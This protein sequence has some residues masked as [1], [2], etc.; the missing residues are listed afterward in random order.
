MTVT[1]P[2]NAPQTMTK[3]HWN[4]KGTARPLGSLDFRADS[5]AKKKKELYI[6]HELNCFIA[7]AVKTPIKER[8]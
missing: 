6:S 5:R 8:T 2:T 1:L 3:V 7:L 4:D